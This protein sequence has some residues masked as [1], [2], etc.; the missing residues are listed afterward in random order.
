[1]NTMAPRR[2]GLDYRPAL[3]TSSGIGRAVREL[4]RA[5]AEHQDVEL[6]LFGHSWAPARRC[7]LPPEAILHRWP[8][9]GRSLPMLAGL[10]LDAP[11]LC[12]K[13]TVF[14]W[15]DYIHPPVRRGAVVLTLHDLAFAEDETF[16]GEISSELLERTSAA[17]ERADVIVTPTRATRQAAIERLG[18]DEARVRVVPF[19]ADHTPAELAETPPLSRPYLL[20]LGTIEPRK[21][22]LRLLRAWDLLPEPRPLLVLIGRRG[23]QCT[24]I[25]AAIEDGT[26]SGNILWFEAMPDADAFGYLRHAAALVYPSL[27]EGFG[28]PPLEAMSMGTPVVAGDNPA[29]RET[30]GDAA[31]YCD[32]L[33]TRSIA[34]TIDEVLHNQALRGTLR[35]RGLAQARRFSW[36][37]C[38]D[39]YADAYAAAASDGNP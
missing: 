14:H 30:L 39:G 22:H 7:E 37:A 20:S 8:I 28:F 4:S 5:L 31:R 32:P 19:G 13:P 38:A 6:R 34:Q 2:V 9:P 15:T 16:H 21:N 17:A 27:L 12:G 18:L 24:N 29:L 3:L 11:A 33:D 26:R 23:W 36:R 35:E 1:M 10:G 25:V